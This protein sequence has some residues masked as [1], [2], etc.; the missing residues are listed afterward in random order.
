MFA[1]MLSRVE[2]LD[3]CSGFEIQAKADLRLKLRGSE[4]ILSHAPSQNVPDFHEKVIALQSKFSRNVGRVQPN[5][6]QI[7]NFLKRF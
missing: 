4:A 2:V 7:F 5:F 6:F 1:L 3:L